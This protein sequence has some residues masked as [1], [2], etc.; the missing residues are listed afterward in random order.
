MKPE[1]DLLKAAKCFAFD[2]TGRNYGD[3]VGAICGVYISAG[4]VHRL[5]LAIQAID[6]KV[7]ENIAQE[8][9]RD[10]LDTADDGPEVAILS[11][12]SNS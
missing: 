10:L 3:V 2:V 9:A 6:A 4:E 1:S 12:D 5:N 8:A 11:C 7:S